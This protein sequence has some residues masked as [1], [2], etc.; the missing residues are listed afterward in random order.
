[1]RHWRASQCDWRYRHETANKANGST[2]T[3]TLRADG[4]RVRHTCPLRWATPWARGAHG[5]EEGPHVHP[6]PLAPLI[7][8]IDGTTTHGLSRST[9]PSAPSSWWPLRKRRISGRRFLRWWWCRLSYPRGLTMRSTREPVVGATT[10]CKLPRST[11]AITACVH[12]AWPPAIGEGGRSAHSDRPGC[13]FC[14]PP[15]VAESMLHEREAAAMVSQVCC[16]SR[17][18]IRVSNASCSPCC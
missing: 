8:Q 4:R 13:A 2:G 11:V 3:G 18:C 5:W 14:R 6:T 17:C 9:S 10:A 7:A 16:G 1:M 12:V 15:G